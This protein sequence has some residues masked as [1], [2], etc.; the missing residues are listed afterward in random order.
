MNEVSLETK[1][2]METTLIFLSLILYVFSNF[3]TFKNK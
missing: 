3:S 1:K 2:E